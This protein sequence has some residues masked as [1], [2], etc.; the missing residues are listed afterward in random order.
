[1]IRGGRGFDNEGFPCVQS[2]GDL[3]PR[4]SE[5]DSVAANSGP[6]FPM[7]H[8]CA[9]TPP[10]WSLKCNTGWHLEHGG[11]RVFD[12]SNLRAAIWRCAWMGDSPATTLMQ[13]RRRL[14]I[15]RVDGLHGHDL[16]P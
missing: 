4:I 12:S 10:T 16:T 2:L 3:I 5:T 8:R 11:L 14:R 6:T 1:M 15:L 13:M 9:C 7:K